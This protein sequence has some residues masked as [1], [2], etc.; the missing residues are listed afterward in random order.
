MGVVESAGGSGSDGRVGSLGCVLSPGW[1]GCVVSPG[2]EVSDGWVGS[3]GCVVPLGAEVCAGCV[4]V[5]GFEVAVGR[6]VVGSSAPVAGSSVRPDRWDGVGAASGVEVTAAA[7]GAPA[8]SAAEPDSGAP[9]CAERGGAGTSASAWNGTP[10]SGC[11]AVEYCDSASSD[12][13]PSAPT[14]ST[15]HSATT[16]YPITRGGVAAC[17]APLPSAL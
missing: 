11:E 12:P 5:L 15:L 2:C 14:T 1:V 8:R 17:G 7:T 10:G 4:V 3:L 16:A 6:D 13:G 9:G